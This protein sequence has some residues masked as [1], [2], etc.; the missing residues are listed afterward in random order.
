MRINRILNNNAVVI[1][2]GNTEKIVLGPGI[3]FQ[4][5]KKDIINE[6]KVEKVFILKEEN[7]KFEELLKKVPEEHILLGEK[8]ISY[9][10]EKLGVDL[11]HHIHISLTDH[12]SFAIERT[13]KGIDVKNK[14]TNE[15]R[16]LYYEEFQIG[17]WAIQHVKEKM[18]IALSIDEAAHIAVHIHTAKMQSTNV[19]ETIN[20]TVIILDMVDIISSYLEIVI[21]KKSLSYQRLVTHLEFAINRFYSDEPF[22]QLDEEMMAMIKRKHDKAFLCAQ[23]AAAFVQAEYEM[24]FPDSEVAYIALHIQRLIEDEK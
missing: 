14:L 1:K 23:H 6:S 10:E 11:N 16:L 2:T 18:G 7:K 21:D 13:E 20:K 9:A 17:L 4:K 8:I 15:I 24:N 12:L 3:A 19:E 22:H 5:S